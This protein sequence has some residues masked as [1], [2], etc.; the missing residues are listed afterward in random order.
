MSASITLLTTRPYGTPVLRVSGDVGGYLEILPTP[1]H[2]ERF[3][4][5]ISDGTLLRGE[6]GAGLDLEMAGTAPLSITDG[7]A[8]VEAPVEWVSVGRTWADHPERLTAEETALARAEQGEDPFDNED[9]LVLA[10]CEL[11][12]PPGVDPSL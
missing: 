4:V 5:A 12:D 3:F 1:A 6:V 10:D 8:T 11:D 9:E 2:G 7:V